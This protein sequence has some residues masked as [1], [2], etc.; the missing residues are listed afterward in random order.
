MLNRNKLKN[1]PVIV[2]QKDILETIEQNDEYED[3][4]RL[5]NEVLEKVELFLTFWYENTTEFGKIRDDFNDSDEVDAEL[6]VIDGRV[7]I[8]I[9]QIDY[10]EN[11]SSD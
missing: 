11:S 10:E 8:K 2:D 7:K 9:G 5:Y 4:L 3:R 6:R 1:A